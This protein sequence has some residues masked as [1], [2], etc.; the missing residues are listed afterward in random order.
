MVV[1][2]VRPAV[3][4]MLGLT[5]R[6]FHTVLHT[7]IKQKL[8]PPRPPGLQQDAEQDEGYAHVE[9]E[10]DFAAFA[11]D[12]EGQTD[13]VAGLEV[14]SEIDG[15]GREP[16]QGL[17]LQEVHTNGAEQRMAEHEPEIRTLGHDDDGLLTGKEKEIDGDDGRHK[18]E[19]SRHL[20][21][22]HRPTAHTHAHFLV[23]DGV[24][25]AGC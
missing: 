4:V 22:Q 15:E 8:L 5:S 10:I 20:I 23:A 11:E 18:N 24:E 1:V 9:G 17:N 6:C 16:L 14:V 13:G 21:H 25:G 12:E 7:S 2:P 19:S 3:L